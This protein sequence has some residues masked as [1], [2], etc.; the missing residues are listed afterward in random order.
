MIKQ[1]TLAYPVD[2][3]WPLSFLAWL[4]D[5]GDTTTARRTPCPPYNAFPDT[6]L[7]L[8]LTLVLIFVVTFANMLADIFYAI[9]DPRIN[10]GPNR[11]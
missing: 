3:P 1:L 4:Y 9:A 11:R 10:Y 8:A 6:P 7:A 2:K 5:P